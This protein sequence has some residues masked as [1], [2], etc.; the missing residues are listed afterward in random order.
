MT[1]LLEKDSSA[2]NRSYQRVTGGCDD[3]ISTIVTLL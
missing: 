1:E 3:A 2:S